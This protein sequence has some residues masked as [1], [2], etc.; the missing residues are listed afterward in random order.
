ML[1]CP[2]LK[3]ESH[4]AP[5]TFL[6]EDRFIQG[7]AASR[8]FGRSQEFCFETNYEHGFTVLRGGPR[9]FAADRVVRVSLHAGFYHAGFGLTA[10]RRR[11]WFY[12]ETVRSSDNKMILT[13]KFL[14]V[15]V[16]LRGRSI[17]P[18][19]QFPVHS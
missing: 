15:S 13:R 1:S 7:A 11:A 4:R 3:L 5:F 19:Q 16:T 2:F 14:N 10:E 9:A 18:L 17:T 6:A 12:A 8:R